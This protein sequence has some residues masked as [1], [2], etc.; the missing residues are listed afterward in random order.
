MGKKKAK[1]NGKD[2]A[3]KR[4]GKLPKSVAGVTISKD[5]RDTIEPVLSWAGSPLVREA[6]A[7][8]LLAGAAA[9]SP[10]KDNED[11]AAK[12]RPGGLGAAAGA[13]GSGG[14]GIGLAI[15][16]AAGEIASRIVTAYQARDD[17]TAASKM[18]GAPPES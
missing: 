18:P 13:S 4:V 2:K 11:S 6:I 14:G 3:R 8:A 9:L 17:R 7:T 16:L 5:L 15:A 1:K 10:G 12:L